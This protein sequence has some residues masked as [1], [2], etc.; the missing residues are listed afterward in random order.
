M[1]KHAKE[2]LKRGNGTNPNL[3]DSY[4]VEF[5]WRKRYDKGMAFANLINHI[6]EVY[7]V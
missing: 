5:I 7:A 2:K 6:A 1:W 3:F 4:L